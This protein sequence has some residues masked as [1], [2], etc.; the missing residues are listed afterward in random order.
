MDQIQWECQH[1]TRPEKGDALQVRAIDISW[2]DWAYKSSTCDVMYRRQRRIYIMVVNFRN[3]IWPPPPQLSLHKR[4]ALSSNSNGTRSYIAERTQ[5]AVYI[6]RCLWPEQ[7]YK[8]VSHRMD[9]TAVTG[10]NSLLYLLCRFRK[11]ILMP[12]SLYIWP[13]LCIHLWIFA[14]KI[15]Y[16]PKRRIFAPWPK[17]LLLGLYLIAIAW[18]NVWI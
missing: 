11:T 12:G 2:L 17:I 3:T 6:V 10:D 18:N 14:F 15:E 9:P 8:T 7:R 13:R 16:G 4:A 1:I 5:N